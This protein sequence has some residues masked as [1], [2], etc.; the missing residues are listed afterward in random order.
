MIDAHKLLHCFPDPVDDMII[1]E[2]YGRLLIINAVE[3][4]DPDASRISLDIASDGVTLRLISISHGYQGEGYCRKVLT[5]L[6]GICCE[7]GLSL[8]VDKACS[9]VEHIFDSLV[10]DCPHIEDYTKIPP[11]ENKWIGPN[12][13]IRFTEPLLLKLW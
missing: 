1:S 7:Q 9:P 12:L 13:E 3:E 4:Y 10:L 8:T 2:S 5:A 6:F 11:T